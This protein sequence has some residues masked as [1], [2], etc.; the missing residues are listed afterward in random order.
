[1]NLLDGDKCNCSICCV[2]D[3]SGKNGTI[4]E[5]WMG[6]TKRQDGIFT[7]YFSEDQF[8]LLPP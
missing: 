3:K 5:P 2:G 1:M 8:I 4:E 7:F 6:R